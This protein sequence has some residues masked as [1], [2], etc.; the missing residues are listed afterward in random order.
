MQSIIY[1]IYLCIIFEK[2]LNF[3][4]QSTV[5][6]NQIQN[7][8]QLT[9]DTQFYE[10]EKYMTPLSRMS[11]E[12]QLNLKQLWTNSISKELRSRLHKAKTPTTLSKVHSISPAV[13]IYCY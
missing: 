8:A 4:S 3:Y 12:K 1:N 13:S 7:S 2:L 9:C 5:I 11:Y 6:F 10:L